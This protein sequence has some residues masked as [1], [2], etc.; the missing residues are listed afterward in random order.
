M[1]VRKASRAI[2]MAGAASGAL[3]AAVSA[4]QA[5]GFINM[6]QSTTY[7]GTSF[8]GIAAPGFSPSGMFINPAIMTEF[9]GIT[10]ENNFSVV[11]PNVKITGVSGVIPAAVGGALPSGDIAQDVLV[12]ASY[13]IIPV[14]AGFTF[15]ASL[16][17]PYGSITK[18][19]IPWGGQLNSLTTK[20]KTY[21]LTPSLAYE[22]SPQLSVG[23]GVQ[24][25]YMKVSFESATGPGPN[26]AAAG[27]GGDGWG[28]GVTAGLTWKPL[29]GTAIGLGYRSRIDQKLEGEYL[30]LPLPAAF[31][32]IKTTV[33]LPDRLNLSIRQA[34]T[35]QFDLLGSVEWINWSRIGT[36]AVS[37]PGVALVP[38]S[39]RSVP[40]EY[41]DGWMFSLGG[42]YR[43]DQNLTLRAGLAYEISPITT[44]VRTTRLPDNDRFWLS[45]GLSYQ[46]TDRITI[47]ASYAHVFVREAD[48]RTTGVFGPAYV[49]QAK[50]HSDVFSL[51]FTTRWTD[52]APAALPRTVVRKG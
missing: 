45:A 9:K 24:I 35:P 28:V 13:L 15:G 20:L 30:G 6:Y 40:L 43:W 31:L 33:K 34:M 36:S 48:I 42:E 26:P 37:G 7:L 19:D 29:Q 11:M 10:T 38:A 12:P 49:G 32:P 50:A 14:G 44:A 22:I 16:N 47:N 21:T 18:P 39:L 1:I 23:V 25:Q 41:K 17:V 4:S 51:G 8:A 5:G 3:M 52:P 2:L 27:L 46:I